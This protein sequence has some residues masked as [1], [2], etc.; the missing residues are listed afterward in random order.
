VSYR[1]R[2]LRRLAQLQE[3][4]ARRLNSPI[5]LDQAA[6]DSEEYGSRLLADDENS[7]IP[8]GRDGIESLANYL[9][10]PSLADRA[11]EAAQRQAM[12]EKLR[13]A[14]EQGGKSGGPMIASI[15]QLD[16]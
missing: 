16:R 13:A 2:Q 4:I 6:I 10:E 12:Q 3:E 15:M 14:S 9:T 7:L 8:I 11:T 1:I 5:D